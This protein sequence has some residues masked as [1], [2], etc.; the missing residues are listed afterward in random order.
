MSGNYPDM[1]SGTPVPSHE[2]SSGSSHSLKIGSYRRNG[3]LHS[4]EP[5]RKG[6][7]GTPLQLFRHT[8]R[9]VRFHKAKTHISRQIEV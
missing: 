6:K 7:G 1:A 3:K 2:R 5:C 8:S 4:C 9:Q